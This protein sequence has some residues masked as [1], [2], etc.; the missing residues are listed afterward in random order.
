MNRHIFDSI[1]IP[2]RK[3]VTISDTT[4]SYIDMGRGTPFLALP[5]W[6]WPSFV[7][8]PLFEKLSA[9]HRVLAFDFPGWIGKSYDKKRRTG[10]DFYT[11][12]T[13][14]FIK[15]LDLRQVILAGYSYGGLVAQQVAQQK[16]SDISQLVL[17]SSPLSLDDAS[18]T[19]WLEMG[20]YQSFRL[21]KLPLWFM[22]KFMEYFFWFDFS[23][24]SGKHALVNTK[25][26]QKIVAEAKSSDTSQIIT[27]ITSSLRKKASIELLQSIPTISIVAEHDPPYVHSARNM[28]Q[29]HGIRTE[30]LSKV[31]HG[32]LV[33]HAD[34]AAQLLSTLL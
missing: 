25:L 26:V 16:Q 27:S 8:L 33:F 13:H 2:H 23:V 4:L 21:L 11:Q 12:L 18:K 20:L 5:P 1:N 22:Q 15:A 17:F 9:S 31:D 14:Q 29:K 6:P 19:H 34:K 10:V 7:Y 28:F 32:H 24:R 30:I 3:K